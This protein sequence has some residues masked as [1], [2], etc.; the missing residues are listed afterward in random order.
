MTVRAEAARSIGADTEAAARMEKSWPYSERNLI[1]TLTPSDTA[2]S[3]IPFR[4]ISGSVSRSD[5]SAC[6]RSTLH[7]AW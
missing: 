1:M 4:A 3:Y 5:S 2:E 6:A 7:P